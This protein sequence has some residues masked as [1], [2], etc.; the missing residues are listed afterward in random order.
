MKLHN[1]K[2]CWKMSPVVSNVGVKLTANCTRVR[3]VVRVKAVFGDLVS[4]AVNQRH[5]SLFI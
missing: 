1:D 5:Y 4:F 3:Q 2:I